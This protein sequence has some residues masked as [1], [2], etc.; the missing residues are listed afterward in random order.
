MDEPSPSDAG[1][2]PM[3]SPIFDLTDYKSMMANIKTD[4]SDDDEDEVGEK[5]P[6]IN[7]LTPELIADV[8]ACINY[9]WSDEDEFV[10]TQCD[11]DQIQC[12]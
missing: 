9:D 8:K 6:R 1:R 11:L 4:P 3:T 12:P 2:L 7:E 10:W 5:K